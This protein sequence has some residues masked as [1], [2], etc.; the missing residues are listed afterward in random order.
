MILL[1]DIEGTTTSISFVYDVLFPYARERCE[2]YLRAHW[3]EPDLQSYVAQ[4]RRDADGDADAGL[5]VARVPASPTV[6]DVVRSVHSQMDLD[7][8]N[9]GLKALQ[10]ALWVS[11]Y[12]SGQ[13]R[14]HVYEDVPVALKRWKAAGI[15]VFIYSSGS[16]SAQKLL[17]GHSEAGDLLPWIAGHFDTEIGG[18][19][20]ASSYTRIAEHL[21]TPAGQITF[22]TDNVLEADAARQAGMN[23]LV[24]DRPG[25][26]PT[27][28]HDHV[29]IQN[30]NSIG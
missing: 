17:F 21:N 16:V 11:G 18:K 26:P 10:G 7:R 6:E 22:A 15:P 27:G 14:G 20:E 13:I 1:L 24:L 30:F 5:A 4:I 12:E 8:K 25:N 9:G 28:P 23:V 29:V 3:D 19:R 2:T